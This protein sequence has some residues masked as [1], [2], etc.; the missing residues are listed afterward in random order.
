MPIVTRRVTHPVMIPGMELERTK[1]FLDNSPTIRLLRADSASFVLDFLQQTFKHNLAGGTIDL[2]QDDL[3]TRL[4]LYQ[5]RLHESDPDVLIGPADRYLIA[6]SD[7]GWLRRFLPATSTQPHYQLTRFSEDALRFVEASVSRRSRIVGT[8]SRLRLVIETL[9]DVV[10]G[11]SPDRDERLRRLQ[12]DRQAIE[13]E[14][15]EI[16]AGGSVST[17]R[18]AQIRERFHTAVNLLK[19]L[20]TDFRAVEDRFAE[21]AAEVQRNSAGESQS[22]GEILAGALD[23]EDLLKEQDE[24]VSFYAFVSFL[25]SP[26]AQAELRQTIRSVSNLAA[27]ADDRAAIEHIRHMVPSLLMEADK[28]LRT[29]GRLSQT[30]RRL[31]DA[32]SAEH[33]RRTAEVLRDI[34]QLAAR[35]REDVIE[36]GDAIVDDLGLTVETSLGLSSPMS[37]LPW[38]PPLVFEQSVIETHEV[39]LRKAEQ[40]GRKLA[41]MQRIELDRMRNVLREATIDRTVTLSELIE[42]RPPKAGVMELVGWLQIAHEDGHRIDT[43]A[44]Q[45]VWISTST[46]G[47]STGDDLSTGDLSTGDLSTG[48]RRRIKVILPLVTFSSVSDKETESVRKQRPR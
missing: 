23:A 9:D 41:Q 37:R 2:P 42:R 5:E 34:R 19:D 7:A 47:L 1:A 25:F 3:R 12:A 30:L 39:D 44:E 4:A 6:W 21:I 16:Q 46:G 14:I 26:D 35:L 45:S 11:A 40:Q 22:R 10:R 33:R 24:G 8:E 17:Y 15:A 43:D 20:Q 27:I 32:D 31:L 28:V 38:T 36:S 18:P 48:D 29:T 13:D